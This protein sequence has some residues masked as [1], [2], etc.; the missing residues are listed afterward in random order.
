[1]RILTAKQI[2]DRIVNLDLGE[3]SDE[4]E[5][6]E[7]VIK[8]KQEKFISLFDHQKVLNELRNMLNHME[9][10]GDGDVLHRDL[11]NFIEKKVDRVNKEKF[12]DILNKS[13]EKG[14]NIA[15]AIR[16][17]FRIGFWLAVFVLFLTPVC[18]ALWRLALS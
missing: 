1:M 16:E 15:R 12:D 8:A 7:E 3:W 18:I 17:G 2:T 14:E 6:E 11:L 5:T 9:V 10:Y 4:A 13:K